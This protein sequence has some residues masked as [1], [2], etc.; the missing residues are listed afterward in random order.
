[1]RLLR[2]PAPPG[3]DGA[4]S[5]H[6]LALKE[7][8]M[9]ENIVVVG[10]IASEPTLAVGDSGIPRVRFRLANDCR[11]RDP[12]TGEW[13]DGETSFYSVTAFRALGEHAYASLRK[14]DRV[15]VTGRLRIS[16][17]VDGELKRSS[18]DITA[19]ALGPDL[20]WGTTSFH[21]TKREQTG[22][23][24]ASASL[25]DFPDAIA[26]LDAAEVPAPF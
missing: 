25:D 7:E 26:V 21:G 8:I 10:N 11:E 12:R 6:R 16:E 1:M 22:D 14:G 5:E 13:R 24:E 2:N 20:R 4:G 9:T 18:A 15:I 17:W 3:H 19:D 23:A